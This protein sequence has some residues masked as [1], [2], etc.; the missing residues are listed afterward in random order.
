MKRL[1]FI[2]LVLI[3]TAGVVFAKDYEVKK[4]A[5][6]YNVEVTIDKNPPV[7]GDNNVKIE[8]RDTAGKYVTDA[9]VVVDYSM[10]AMPGMPA[11]NYK[12]DAELKGD[13]YRAK[14][15]LSM[16]GSWNIAVKITKAGKTSTMKFT[17]DAK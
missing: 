15:N 5:G 7:I 12:T 17:V 4:K 1:M 3:M 11:M 13:E 14:M 16:S 6:D 2:T 8:I 9:K 10:P